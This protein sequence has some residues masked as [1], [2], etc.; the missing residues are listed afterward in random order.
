MRSRMHVSG[1][2]LF[3][4]YAVPVFYLP[5]D[6]LLSEQIMLLPPNYSFLFLLRTS[7]FSSIHKYASRVWRP[8]FS[9]F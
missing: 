9:Q 4:Y 6:K 8:E 1:S 3:L 7:T 2:L 5:W